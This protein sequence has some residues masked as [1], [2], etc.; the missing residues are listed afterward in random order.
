MTDVRTILY[1][2]LALYL[3]GLCLLELLGGLLKRGEDEVENV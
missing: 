1:V 3:A 2:W